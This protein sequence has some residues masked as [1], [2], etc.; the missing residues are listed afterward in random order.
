MKIIN[1]RLEKLWAAC[2]KY[3]NLKD[4]LI[5]EITYKIW[6][7]K[8]KIQIDWW[9]IS[10]PIYKVK[11]SFTPKF[12]EYKNRI[13]T[14]QKELDEEYKPIIEDYER[15]IEEISQRE[16]NKQLDSQI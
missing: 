2:I 10:L 9:P 16:I 8:H 15:Q 11:E 14:F 13:D 1:D 12:Q 3:K 7:Q 6:K 5:T 4:C